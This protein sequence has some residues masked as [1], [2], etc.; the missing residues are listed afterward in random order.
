MD[1]KGRVVWEGAVARADRIAAAYEE[2]DFCRV[3]VEVREIADLANL[4]FAEMEPW[5]LAKTDLPLARR[6]LTSTLN[7][8]RVLAIYLKP[9]L[10]SY[11]ERVEKLFNA[12]PFAWDDLGTPFE[13]CA[14]APY[15]YL[16]TRIESEQI[17]N[18]VEASKSG[19]EPADLPQKPCVPVKPEIDVEAFSKVDLR[20]AE[21]LAAEAVEGADKLLRLTLDIG[22]GKP[23]NVFAG[24]RKAYDPARLVGRR[25][26]MVANLAPRK[27]KFGVSEGMVLAASNPGAGEADLFVLSP[28]DGFPT[29][30]KK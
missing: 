30:E 15:E 4:Y 16:A 3:M 1:E 28:D 26:V 24:I 5:K 25:V 18:M 12:K 11:A 17:K 19:G 6:V 21:V 9:I 13:N 8:F 10:P 29:R 7:I 2:R 27:M 20:V 22:E 23:R 14:V